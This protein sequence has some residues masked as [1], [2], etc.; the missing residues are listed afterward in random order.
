MTF[1]T[2]SGREMLSIVRDWSP[3]PSSPNLTCTIFPG[4]H[5][6][7]VVAVGHVDGGDIGFADGVRQGG[8]DHPAQ[9]LGDV[10]GGEG[11][12]GAEHFPHEHVG[13]TTLYAKTP[14]AEQADHAEL[15]IPHEH[16]LLGAPFLVGKQPGADEEDLRLKGGIEAV[17]PG[18]QL[19]EHR[20]ILGG[21]GVWPGA[22]HVGKGTLVEE[23]RALPLP[24][25]SAG[26]PF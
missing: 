22:E 23:N 18:L 10:L 5:P 25:E 19:G 9:V 17:F 1:S 11:G 14:K 16:R 6:Q 2:S 15:L 7:L 24:D 12:Q 3:R 26:R 8:G 4:F 20:H 13:C 21:K